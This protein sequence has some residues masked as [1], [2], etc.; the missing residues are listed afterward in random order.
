[1]ISKS[2]LLACGIEQ[3]FSLFTQQISAWWPSNRRHT[4]D[5]E[6]KLFLSESGRFWEQASDGTEV[7]LG[8]VREWQAPHRLLLDFYIG[9]GPQ[10]PTEVEVTFSQEAEKTR[11]SI[12][13]RP[14]PES[15]SAWK[16]KAHLFES[17]WGAVLSCLAD[18]AL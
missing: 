8:Q 12:V 11:V 15:L 7:E 18:A 4:K 1:M 9:T 2:V 5:P 16:T 6:S 14:K 13:H 10:H 17:S 3:A